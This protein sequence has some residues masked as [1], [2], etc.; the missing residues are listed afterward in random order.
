VQG[1]LQARSSFREMEDDAEGILSNLF[2]VKN[3]HCFDLCNTDSC[4]K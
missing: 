4:V 1:V 3:N 2:S